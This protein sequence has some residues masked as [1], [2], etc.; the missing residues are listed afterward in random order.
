MYVNAFLLT[1]VLAYVHYILGRRNRKLVMV[2]A[3]GGT[4]V[5]GGKETGFTAYLFMLFYIFTM[6]MN[7]FFN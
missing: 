1:C 2:A 5:Q 4:A 6:Y 7:Y 3:Q